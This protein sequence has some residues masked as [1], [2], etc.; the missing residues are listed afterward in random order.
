MH[1]AVAAAHAE[2]ERAVAEGTRDARRAELTDAEAAAARANAD[3][4]NHAAEHS[5]PSD[6]R[7]ADDAEQALH[8]VA[9]AVSDL[10]LAVR[11]RQAAGRRHDDAL[12]HRQ[13]AEG[14]HER[15]QRIA[16]LNRPGR[17]ARPAGHHAWRSDREVV[18][19]RLCGG[20]RVVQGGA[21]LGLSFQSGVLACRPDLHLQGAAVDVVRPVASM[22]GQ[23]SL[24]GR[25]L[26][27][28]DGFIRAAGRGHQQP[29]M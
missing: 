10:K 8:G 12:A 29:L 14:E 24:D 9:A 13:R 18:V 27:S 2:R 3:V 17:H 7:G 28:Q 23:H 11:D 20:D 16:R 22:A 1:A 15:A 21:Q 25:L 19:V 5:L 26:A 6:R 4:L